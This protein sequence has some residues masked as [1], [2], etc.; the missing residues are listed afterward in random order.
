MIGEL[1]AIFLQFLVFGCCLE[2]A[3]HQN[4]VGLTTQEMTTH[5]A[6][7]ESSF[8]FRERKIYEPK[9]PNSSCAQLQANSKFRREC[10][11]PNQ[12][13]QFSAKTVRVMFEFG[14]VG[15]LRNI[16]V[17]RF[18]TEVTARFG[19]EN[20]R[21]QIP[22]ERT[23]GVSKGECDLGFLQNPI[24]RPSWFSSNQEQ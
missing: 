4:T 21:I 19:I 20:S 12:N 16:F 5:I 2:M 8:R 23:D 22:P 3:F 15:F 14:C 18:S 24:L 13:F 11:G 6:F 1:I 17:R 7:D 9:L 10:N